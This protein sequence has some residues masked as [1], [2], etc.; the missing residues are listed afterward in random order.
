MIGVVYR[1]PQSLSR[2]KRSRFGDSSKFRNPRLA[3]P[4]WKSGITL[5]QISPGKNVLIRILDYILVGVKSYHDSRD[6]KKI[7]TFFNK[8][9]VKTV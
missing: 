4:N 1:V 8:I 2:K 7:V 9:R 5:E 6:S 3:V